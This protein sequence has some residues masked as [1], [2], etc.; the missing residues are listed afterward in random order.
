[1]LELNDAP[2]NWVNSMAED[3]RY[4]PQTE[5]RK[6]MTEM[7]R[8]VGAMAL[9]VVLAMAGHV[10][11]EDSAKWAV[12]GA[13]RMDVAVVCDGAHAFI[14]YNNMVGPGWK[15]GRLEALA[16][17]RDGKRVFTQDKVGFYREWW[18]KDPMPGRVDLQYELSQTGD[19]TFLMRYKLSPDAGMSIGFPK[20]LGEPSAT[21][22]PVLRSEPLFKGGH[23]R[24]TMDDGRTAEH[25]YPV[26][27]GGYDAVT[28]VE[29]LTASGEAL[30]LTFDPP[31]FVH[32]DNGELRCM[33][34]SQK[35]VARKAGE[36]YSQAITLQLPHPA[37]LEPDNRYVD[38]SNWFVYDNANDFS[39]GSPI[40]MDD[41]LDKPAGRH[42]WL[43]ADGARLVFDDGTVARFW[44]GNT[45]HNKVMSEPEAARQWARRYAKYGA[46]LMRWHK[47]THSGNKSGG[48][49]LTAED[50]T[51]PD[52]EAMKKFDNFHAELRNNGVYLLWS[53]IYRYQLSPAD[54]NRIEHYDE[55]I[56]ALG[57][58]GNTVGLVNFIPELQDLYIKVTTNLLNHRNE[59]TGLRY[60]DDPALAMIEMRNED[61]VFFWGYDRLIQKCPTYSKRLNQRFAKWLVAQYGSID[62]TAQAWGGLAKGESVEEGISPWSGYYYQSLPL[63][64]R[65]ADSYRFLFELQD[66]FYKRYEKAIRD[67]GYKG[68]LIGS[69]W[70]AHSFIGHLW[71]VYSDSRIGPI[72]RH[73]YSR[74]PLNLPGAGL[75]S[76]F[77]QA[78]VDRPFGFSEWAGGERYGCQV[79]MPMVAIY[80]MGLQGWDYSNN[81]A[82]DEAPIPNY[83]GGLGT[84]GN[85]LATM[86]QY[87]SLARMIYR[88]DVKEGDIVALR[89]VGVANLRDGD[90]GFVEEF[91]LLGG[92]GG[93]PRWAEVCRRQGREACRSQ[94]WESH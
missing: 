85:R 13:D 20:D 43:K 47:W 23:V 64:R 91:N 70:Q 35:G 59:V 5:R 10:A 60:A 39:P 28:S 31:L 80:G 50:H 40:G 86:A 77:L 68:V 57:K 92:A 76:C 2:L 78:V 36:A 27:R 69:C 1:M 37:A 3:L 38:I 19:R 53:H 72:D 26:P 93:R 55:V 61:C 42:G 11:A 41:W 33:I 45:C 52:A 82:E 65:V 30:R 18:E 25:P 83:Y 7:N 84:V 21:L 94:A 14:L 51:V 58:D 46:N 71:N 22:G 17:V 90:P 49:V 67:T 66:E 6:T 75:M 8:N 44:G 4:T 73:N 32:C 79:D 29:V 62:A 56:T 89:T 54:K 63:T 15:G 87:P 12:V 9:C 88:G 16:S 24:L 34:G 74:A 81:F 48:G